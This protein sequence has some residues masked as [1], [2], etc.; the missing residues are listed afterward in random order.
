MQAME[1]MKILTWLENIYIGRDTFI[2]VL[3]DLVH[4][5]YRGIFQ[6]TDFKILKIDRV[7]KTYRQ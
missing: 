6:M 5:M 1:F 2:A 3:W 7:S 4:H